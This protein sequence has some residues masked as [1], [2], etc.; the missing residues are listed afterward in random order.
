MA[1]IASRAIGNRGTMEIHDDGSTVVMRIRSADAATYSDRIPI[2]V[3]VGGGWSGWFNVNYSKGSPWVNVWSGYIGST[4]SV[5]FAVGNTGTSGFGTGGELWASI[6][7]TP[8]PTVPAKPGTPNASEVTS[9]SMRLTWGIPSD[10]GSGIDQMLLR[11]SSDPNFGSYVDYPNA[12]NVNSRVVTDLVPGAT[13][14]WRVYAHNAVGYSVS[15]DTR[16]QATLPGGRTKNGGA[17]V[18]ATPWEK[19][20]GTWVRVLPFEKQA[21]AWRALR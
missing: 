3:Y 10:G 9:T 4:Q 14:Y 16:T 11:R 15:S 13:Y 2:R 7:R 17:W 8:P 21:G 19:V 6:N 1:L 5:A 12:G 20:G 18:N